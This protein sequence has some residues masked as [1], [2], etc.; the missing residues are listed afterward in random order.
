[1]AELPRSAAKKSLPRRTQIAL[2]P[3][4]QDRI[5]VRRR[6]LDGMLGGLWEFPTGQLRPDQAPT[7]AARQL[8][9]EL[10]YGGKMQELGKIRHSY[11]HFKLEI[12]SYLVQLE[13]PLPIAERDENQQWLTLAELAKL[14]L[15]GA[16]KK[17]FAR[18]AHPG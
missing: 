12:F 11:S 1:Q 17:I 6:G 5:L 15:H 4:W 2:L 7:R 10:G 16:H 8:L 3:Q 18:L 14:P 13:P 9:A